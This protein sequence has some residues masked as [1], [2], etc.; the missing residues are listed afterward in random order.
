[1]AKLQMEKIEIVSSLR[2][3]KSILE[4]LQRHG[5]VELIDE[6]GEKLFKFNTTSEVL[7]FEKKYTM[8]KN[9]LEI[10]KKYTSKKSPLT[11]NL[12]G[13]KTIS[14]N[15]F[16]KEAQ[17][18]DKAMDICYKILEYTKRIDDMERD[19]AK[20]KVS[21]SQ[22]LP[23]ESLSLPCNFEGT[24][25]TFSFIGQFPY[26]VSL[27]EIEEN[28]KKDNPDL[29]FHTD[30]IL[31]K[32]DATYAVITAIKKYKTEIL[33]SISDMGFT[34]IDKTDK[35]AREEINLL[36]ESISNATKEIKDLKE[37]IIS[38]YPSAFAIEFVIDYFSIKID[39]YK[40]ISKLCATEKTIVIRGYIPKKYSKGLIEDMEKK[41]P[42]AICIETPKE[43][44]DVPVEVS[45][46]NFLRL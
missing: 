31:E 37:K 27:T 26:A 34:F 45:T 46:V 12:K 15:E 35:P 25:T 11:D 1:M 36:N 33:T 30:I 8:A 24:E 40:A 20:W 39:K 3:S 19:I 38:F 7:R 22:F 5:V 28:I 10:L 41:Y 21:I 18:N 44:D 29:V 4:D 6:N 16:L 23:Y 42:V 2:N 43:D 9:A 32:K 14:K 17:N 13:R